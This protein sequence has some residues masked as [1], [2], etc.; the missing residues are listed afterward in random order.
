MANDFS[1]HHTFTHKTTTH[2][3][4]IRWTRIGATTCPPLIFI[5]GTPWS[6]AVWQ[7]LATSLS[8]RYNIYLY[9]HPGFGLS[10]PPHHLMDTGSPDQNQDHGKVDL[11]ASL[12]L[13]AEQAPRCS[14]TGIS[15][16]HPT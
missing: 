2:D 8:T 4:H 3:N 15:Q 7:N 5:H 14:P 6:S 10:P 9:D 11:D 12:V 13:R 16:P 1:L